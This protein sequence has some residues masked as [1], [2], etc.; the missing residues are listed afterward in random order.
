MAFYQAALSRH[1]SHAEG[2]CNRRCFPKVSG[3]THRR[4][5]IEKR[6]LALCDR[7]G[8]RQYC[9]GGVRRQRRKPRQLS[10]LPVQALQRVGTPEKK[11][12]TSFGWH[13]RIDEGKCVELPELS[14]PPARAMLPKPW[15]AKCAIASSTAVRMMKAS[16]SRTARVWECAGS[17]LLT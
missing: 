2:C 16:S 8:N 10:R 1:G 11:D 7:P 9:V 4:C 3:G 15:Y 14:P 6:G 5:R 17:A 12:R 13:E